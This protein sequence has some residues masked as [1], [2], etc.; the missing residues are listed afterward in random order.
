MS[1]QTEKYPRKFETVAW[2]DDKGSN[3]Q[4]GPKNADKFECIQFRCLPSADGW[5]Y[6][7]DL[8]PACDKA[9]PRG[10]FVLGKHSRSRD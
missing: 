5:L 10:I 8:R 7:R 4:W 2:Y 1:H 6:R 3:K 9:D